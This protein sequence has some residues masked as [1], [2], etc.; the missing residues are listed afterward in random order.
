MDF[1]DIITTILPEDIDTDH[2]ILVVQL[3]PAVHPVRLRLLDLLDYLVLN[4]EYDDHITITHQAI[5]THMFD[6]GI[7][8][9]AHSLLSET[10][11]NSHAA[12]D[13]H[14]ADDDRHITDHVNLSNIGLTSHDDIDRH[15]DTSSIHIQA[16]SIT[17][18]TL[19]NGW[20]NYGGSFR[21]AGYCKDSQ[22]FVHL[23]GVI[24]DGTITFGTTIFTLPTGF[25]PV[26]GMWKSTD[27]NG[28][29]GRLYVSST[30]AVQCSV[31]PSNASLS[32]D[33]V[34]FLAA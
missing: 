17:A 3:T 1:L 12:I 7:H 9:T 25:R 14:L 22:G 5:E 29:Y 27:C 6:G 4:S 11:T 10:G 15:I 20:V 16:I 26:A 23:Q 21:N 33:G 2:E 19:G 18:P 31:V 30:G 13:L 8:I 34:Y 28:G 24:K 32:L